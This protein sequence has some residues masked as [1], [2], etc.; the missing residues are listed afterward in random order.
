MSSLLPSYVVVVFFFLLLNCDDAHLTRFGEN[1]SIR[2]ILSLDFIHW[3]LAN[4]LFGNFW[5]E[6]W[7]MG[8]IWWWWWWC[9]LITWKGNRPKKTPAISITLWVAFQKFA[10]KLLCFI[11]F[12]LIAIESKDVMC[13]DSKNKNFSKLKRTDS[14]EDSQFQIARINNKRTET[15]T[16]QIMNNMKMEEERW[17]LLNFIHQNYDKVNVN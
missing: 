15:R 7:P 17:K 9:W 5:L 1:V 4:L 11:V 8:K 3:I 12:E 16:N 2:L 10:N 14:L 13:F 6:N